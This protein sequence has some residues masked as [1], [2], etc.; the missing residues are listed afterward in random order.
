VDP[1]PAAQIN[2]DPCGSGSAALLFR[3]TVHGRVG[4]KPTVQLRGQ[5]MDFLSIIIPAQKTGK[6]PPEVD[7]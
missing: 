3:A 7:T 2:A 1:D 4:L 6:N 5:K